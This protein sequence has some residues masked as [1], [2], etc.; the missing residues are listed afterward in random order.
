MTR[1]K[2]L[3]LVS[4]GLP[5]G[6]THVQLKK[7]VANQ[8]AAAHQQHQQQVLNNL[9][10]F[11]ANPQST[12]YYSTVNSGFAQVSDT[13]TI[14]GSSSSVTNSATTLAAS[15]TGSRLNQEQFSLVPITDPYRLSWMKC[16]YQ[17]AVGIEVDPSVS[18]D[19]CLLVRAW[20]QSCPE[21]CQNPIPNGNSSDGSLCVDCLP[22]SGWFC[23]GSK[24]DVPKSACFVGHYNDTY[25]W[26]MRAGV[27]EF[28]KL[29]ALIGGIATIRRQTSMVKTW[30]CDCPG[31]SSLK[32]FLNSNTNCTV[33]Q[34]TLI[35]DAGISPGS[36]KGSESAGPNLAPPTFRLQ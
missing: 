26:V 25:I 3:I 17:S 11:A 8:A 30:P 16:A 12:P 23:V 22:Q 15:I 28:G 35:G 31:N 20:A 5:L 4:A 24:H 33:Q 7:D 29:D 27:E 9:A 14:G 13:G 6:C 32:S 18:G 1:L 21:P 19:L 2:I 36:G 10:M 34:V